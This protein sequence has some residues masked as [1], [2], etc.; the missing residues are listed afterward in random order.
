M[1]PLC[2]RAR[3]LI[4]DKFAGIL[5]SDQKEQIEKHLSVC[6]VCQAFSDDLKAE[7]QQLTQL[8][9]RLDYDMTKRKQRFLHKRCRC[10][11]S[12]PLSI[13]RTIMKTH[14]T[15][16]ASV[17]AVICLAVLGFWWFRAGPDMASSAYAEFAQ[18]I[19]NSKAAEWVHYRT[20]QGGEQV[21]GWI[22]MQ[23]YRQFSR[24]G[25]S[26]DY[27]DGQTAQSFHYDV[28]NRTL[29]M[30]LIPEL[31]SEPFVTLLKKKSFLEVALAGFEHLQEDQKL[32]FTRGQ[33]IIDGKTY[34]ILSVNSKTN[35]D[36]QMQIT[37]DPAVHQI[38]SIMGP[39]ANSGERIT[40]NLDYPETG[41]ADI[42]EF[43]VPR[44]AK[45]VDHTAR[46]G[47]EESE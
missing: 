10:Q 8:V 32:Q 22:S 6:P 27:I 16:C 39:D 7:H 46:Q 18:A 29:T 26:I 14:W 44:D 9:A 20:I 28:S 35:K 45:I 38:I 23:P 31:R 36:M 12:K 5:T 42:Y 21:E 30:K 15:K 1:N 17:A 37:I 25:N 2:K 34:T 3:D 43:G 33:R 11:E 40:I 19:E 24:K 47:A 4:A 13:R 41:P